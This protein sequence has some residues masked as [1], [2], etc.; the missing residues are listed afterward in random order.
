MNRSQYLRALGVE[1]WKLREVHSFAE[2]KTLEEKVS[3]KNS[4]TICY[5]L[6]FGAFKLCFYEADETLLSKEIW[7]DI[8]RFW[9]GNIQG[10][11]IQM[12]EFSPPQ[13]QE[14]NILPINSPSGLVETIFNGTKRVIFFGLRWTEIYPEIAELGHMDKKKIGASDVLL[15][16]SVEEF[17]KTPFQKRQVMVILDGWR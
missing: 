2:A 13:Y 6:S 3:S 8:A 9:M 11:K 12:H 1:E 15:L 5:I 10:D 17:L 4:P 16:R 7:R 14:E